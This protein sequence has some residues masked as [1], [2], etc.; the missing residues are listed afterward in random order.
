MQVHKAE[1]QLTETKE[2]REREIRSLQVEVERI[3][4]EDLNMKNATSH[5][6]AGSADSL[7]K[8]QVSSAERQS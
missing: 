2:Q 5:N 1:R 7:H 6:V 4:G 3:R 8:A